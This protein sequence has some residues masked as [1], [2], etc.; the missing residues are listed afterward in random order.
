MKIKNQFKEKKLTTAVPVSRITAGEAAKADEAVL[1]LEHTLDIYINEVL[2]MKLICTAD[3]LTELVLGRLLSE[4]IIRSMQDIEALYIC[5]SGHRAKV[6]LTEKTAAASRGN[7]YVETTPTCCTDN[8]T[9][10]DSFVFKEE[11]SP[12]SPGSWTAKE[13]TLCAEHFDQDSP[14][15]EDTLF[16]H[17]CYLLLNGEIVFEAEDI[18][19]HNALDKVLGY[20]LLHDADRQ[21]AAVFTSGRVP[22][23]MVRKVIRAGVP[24]FILKS[25]AT[26]EAVELANRYGLTIIGNIRI[27]GYVIYTETSKRKDCCL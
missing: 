4:G 18:G 14:L 9:L 12:L 15:H 1:L 22:T 25:G 27:D 20:A 7:T 8:R 17:V 13:V 10:N 6:F 5:E 3:H 11:L 19:R 26:K 21:N 23:D 24:V 2:T 16:T